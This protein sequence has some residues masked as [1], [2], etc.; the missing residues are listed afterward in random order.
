MATHH[1]RPGGRLVEV[2]AAFALIGVSVA[3]L[4]GALLAAYALFGLLVGM[5][6]A[7]LLAVVVTAAL[8]RFIT[9]V[10]RG[11]WWLLS[12]IWGPFLKY[13]KY[14]AH[15]LRPLKDEGTDK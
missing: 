1:G 11:A 14:Q 3:I 5:V 2:L 4:V 9:S 10:M 7:W 15:N 12:A 6:P 13:Y 8:G